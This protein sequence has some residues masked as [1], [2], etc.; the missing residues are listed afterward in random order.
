MANLLGKYEIQAVLGQG[1]MGKVYRAWDPILKRQVA[2]KTISGDFGANADLLERFKRE[3]ESAAG[4][5]H[6]NV[7]TIYDMGEH[8]GTPYIAMEF[9]EGADLQSMIFNRR[10]AT[11]NQALDIVR[12]ACD[13]LHYAH[14]RKIVHRDV[15][16][17]NVFVLSDGT[18]KIVDFGIAR[19]GDSSQTQTGMVMG[20]V[21]YMSP[22]QIRGQ[23]LDGRSDQFSAGIILYEVLTGLKPFT[24]EGI[25]QVF[26]QI[27]NQEPEP[28][29]AR[30]PN[31]PEALQSVVGRSL[32]KNRE[33]RYPDMGAMSADI[34]QILDSLK[35][36]FTFDEPVDF[37][38]ETSTPV[39]VSQ[40][41]EVRQLAGRG[42]F[43]R[44]KLRLKEFSAKF[45]GRD[46]LVD[47]QIDNARS[48]VAFL[49]NR[50]AVARQME[51]IQQLARDCKFQPAEHLLEQ[52]EKEY[53]GNQDLAELRLKLLETRRTGEKTEF[54]RT[55]VAQA[56]NFQNASEFDRAI[57]VV[58]EA[59][60]MYPEERRLLDFYTK[61]MDQKEVE[62]RKEYVRR[63]CASVSQRLQQ[64]SLGDALDEVEQAMKRYPSEPVIQNLYR[65]LSSRKKGGDRPR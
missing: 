41:E 13:G 28:V 58:D 43:E 56:L 6:F 25:P 39:P 33:D 11:L 4:L 3:A 60:Q 10:I 62:A 19:V 37:C 51:N 53:P 49:E 36:P 50:E 15:K 17:A 8:C 16:P 34:K 57:D 22:E 18:V 55:H 40:L 26:Y 20:T 5:K 46:P 45:G 54:I 2:L 27:A 9:L 12:Q 1:A 14:A 30:Y 23:K 64:G 47:F 52:L 59:L 61:L 7:V 24:G 63:T 48:L 38:W 65:N 21:S 32:A 44:A 29:R 35:R 31:C 42:E